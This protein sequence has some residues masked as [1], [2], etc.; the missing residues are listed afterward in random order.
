MGSEMCIR[1]S[2]SRIGI[3]KLKDR[4]LELLKEN[5]IMEVKPEGRTDKWSPI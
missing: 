1:D 4:L 5:D 2:F 3:E